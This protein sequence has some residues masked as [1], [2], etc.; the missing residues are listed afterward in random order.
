MFAAATKKHAGQPRARPN[1]NQHRWL[2]CFNDFVGAAGRI[3]PAGADDNEIVFFG[4]GFPENLSRYRTVLWADGSPGMHHQGDQYVY[5][6]FDGVAKSAVAG[7]NDDLKKIGA[8]SEMG[9][10][11]EHIDHRR[12]ADVTRAA[13]KKSAAQSADE[14]DQQNNPE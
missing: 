5:V 1:C 10:N 7:G 14:R 9:W 3:S 13:A 11:S 4:G 12:H 8:D 6:A 2:N